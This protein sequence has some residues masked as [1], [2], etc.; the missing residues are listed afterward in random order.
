MV[1]TSLLLLPSAKEL[2]DLSLPGRQQSLAP[3]T[4]TT[5]RSPLREVRLDHRF[6]YSRCKETATLRYA[7]STAATMLSPASDFQHD[8]PRTRVKNINDCPFGF[9]HGVSQNLRVGLL[10]QDLGESLPGHSIQAVLMSRIATSGRSL[11]ASSTA[12]LP[13]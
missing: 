9:M 11:S 13:F 8:A 12:S 4:C 6:R 2:N 7:L 5:A 3:R 1:A 10:L